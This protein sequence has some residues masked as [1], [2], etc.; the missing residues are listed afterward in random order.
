MYQPFELET[1]VLLAGDLEYVCSEIHERLK[2]EIN[3]VG[4][5]FK[6]LN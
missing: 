4:L 6:V 5:M 2:A 3:E 1:Q